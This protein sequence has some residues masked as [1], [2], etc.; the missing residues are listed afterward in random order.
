MLRIK[1]IDGSPETI[2]IE[3]G[4]T[5]RVCSANFSAT[6]YKEYVIIESL[7]T[8]KEE[9]KELIKDTYLN[10]APLSS[11]ED[12]TKLNKLIGLG[13]KSASEGSDA[14]NSGVTQSATTV[15]TQEFGGFTVNAELSDE[16]PTSDQGVVVY[17][18]HQLRFGYAVP[19]TVTTYKW[20]KHWATE[21]LYQDSEGQIHKNVIFI[22]AGNR[23]MNVGGALAAYVSSKK[24]TK[25]EVK[26]QAEYDALTEKDE[27]TFYVIVEG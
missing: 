8:G 9:Y 18:E 17:I 15:R 13:Y 14:G 12:I 27:S 25:I 19:E 23:Y 20:Y 2:Q 11:P 3:Q 4:E 6:T 26:T 16:T 5:T 1:T 21:H 7:I 10:G 24:V 22:C